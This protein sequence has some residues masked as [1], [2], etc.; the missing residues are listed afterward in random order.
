MYSESISYRI[1]SNLNID[2]KK[3]RVMKAPLSLRVK[4]IL[5]NPDAHRY[6]CCGVQSEQA[7][8]L[9]EILSE[10]EVHVQAIYYVSY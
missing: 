5:T 6:S 3:T 7:S 10:F 1:L 2:R 9:V 8:T 4:V